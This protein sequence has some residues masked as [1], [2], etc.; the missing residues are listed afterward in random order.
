M[1][2]EHVTSQ[3]IRFRD[4]R[5]WKQFHTPKN[6]AAALAIEAAELQEAMLWKTDT[7]AE[8]LAASKA[9]HQSLSDEVADVMI[10][11]LLF[12][13]SAGIDPSAAIQMKLR[14]NAENYPVEKARGKAAKYNVLQDEVRE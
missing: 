12:C 6:L 2:L 11:V 14:K 4:E 5:D 1:D 3:V 10:Y 13:E 9:G 7:E 8:A